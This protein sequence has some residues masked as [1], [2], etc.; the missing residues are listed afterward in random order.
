MNKE[1]DKEK[2]ELEKISALKHKLKTTLHE[3]FINNKLDKLYYITNAKWN[4]EEGFYDSHYQREIYDLS[5]IVSGRI[6]VVVI[7]SPYYNEPN[8]YTGYSDNYEGI[9]TFDKNYDI[10]C[11]MPTRKYT[12]NQ[13]SKVSDYYSRHKCVRELSKKGVSL[14]DAFNFASL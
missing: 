14:V 2:K 4:S 6:Y 10:V 3:Q 9:I 5:K 7:L 12:M 11:L 1:T 8:I 13:S